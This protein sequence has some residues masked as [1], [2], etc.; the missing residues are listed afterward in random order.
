MSTRSYH[1]LYLLVLFIF[2]LCGNTLAFEFTYGIVGLHGVGI[3]TKISS[4]FP[5]VRG[6]SLSNPSSLFTLWR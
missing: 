4:F 3:D 6:V 1:D 5:E 2:I